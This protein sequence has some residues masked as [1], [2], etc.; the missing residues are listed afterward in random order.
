M[1]PTG[2]GLSNC[3]IHIFTFFL[4]WSGGSVVDNTLDYQ[5]RDR[6]IDLPLLRSF[7]LDFKLSMTSL[8]VRRYTRAHLLTHLLF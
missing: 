8:L 2:E 1:S 6:N 3:N 5:S 7:G 4:F